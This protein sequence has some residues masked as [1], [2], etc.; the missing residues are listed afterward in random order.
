M[1]EKGEY[2]SA[3]S[4]LASLAVKVLEVMEEAVSRRACVWSF[5][6]EGRSSRRTIIRSPLALLLLLDTLAIRFAMDISMFSFTM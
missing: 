1:P 2:I 4:H 5:R 3:A 6:S